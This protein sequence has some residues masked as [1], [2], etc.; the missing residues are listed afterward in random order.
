MALLM[1]GILTLTGTVTLSAADLA[2]ENVLADAAE[3]TVLADEDLPEETQETPAGTI[4]I[5]CEPADPQIASTA[6]MPWADAA[7]AN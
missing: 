6:R 2:E 1:A 5:F 7:C 3:E 4:A